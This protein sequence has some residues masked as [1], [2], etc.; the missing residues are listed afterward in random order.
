LLLLLAVSTQIDASS[1]V[2]K[3]H[4]QEGEKMSDCE[5]CKGFRYVFLYFAIHSYFFLSVLVLLTV[6]VGSEFWEP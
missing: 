2:R 3:E 1:H 6:K 5:R 4:Y